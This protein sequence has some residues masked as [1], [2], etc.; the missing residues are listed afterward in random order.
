M[1]VFGIP[2]DRYTITGFTIGA[3]LFV[4]VSHSG[5]YGQYTT[6]PLEK[7]VTF[8]V[9]EEEMVYCFAK[10]D[11]KPSKNITELDITC[12][13]VAL[14]Q[15]KQQEMDVYLDN[16]NRQHI[17]IEGQEPYIDNIEGHNNI[18]EDSEGFIPIAPKEEVHDSNSKQRTWSEVVDGG[19]SGFIDFLKENHDGE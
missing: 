3:V 4:L 19:I 11:P 13:M 18:D 17:E 5:V 2:I 7:E 16:W 1:K 6:A 14:P 9:R 10:A 15:D 12:N 8:P